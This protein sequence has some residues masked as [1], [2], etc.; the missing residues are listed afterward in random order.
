MSRS[1]FNEL[2]C[3]I[4]IYFGQDYDLIDDTVHIEPKVRI[5]LEQEHP[6]SWYGLMADIEL[7]LSQSKDLEGRFRH[8]YGDEF[9]P[10]LW[11]TT[12]EGFLNLVLGM[13]SDAISE[14]EENKSS[15]S[16]HE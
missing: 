1:D 12:A 10:E 8:Y 15:G 7:F 4:T 14:Y 16:R 11:N 9:D 13:I 3:F 2:N 6:S 5:F